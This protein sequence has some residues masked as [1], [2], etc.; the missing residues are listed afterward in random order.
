M[1]PHE[2]FR[3]CQVASY[4]QRVTKYALTLPCRQNRCAGDNC[5]HRLVYSKV[6]G[7]ARKRVAAAL[8]LTIAACS[9][10]YIL[11]SS[12][13]PAGASP[14][15]ALS[16]PDAHTV[17]ILY[18]LDQKQNDQ[19]LISLIDAAKAHVYFAI[20]EF[21]LTD[22]AKALVR[23]KQR[24]VD[25]RGLVDRKESSSSYDAP[26]I[27]LLTDAGI[28]VETQKHASGTGIMHIK[29][30]VTENAYAIGSYNWTRSATTV[31]DE[32]LE[33]GTD[34]DIVQSYATLLERLFTKYEGTSAA[35]A[36]EV[37]SGGTYTTEEAEDHI[38]EY[39][40]V[41]GTLVDA[42][43]SASGTVFLDFCDNYK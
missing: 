17:R 27:S 19:E 41:T 40:S 5:A 21:T 24:G 39:A 30:L 8:V 13:T 6:M 15:S 14:G 2:D 29:A 4:A 42:Y 16:A 23:A 32:V 37:I 12:P 31:N 20:Y 11:G 22:V 35:N 10:G 1:N 26:A 34:P 33:I 3:I 28:P 25:V 18:S 38:G 7:T 43:T 36:A 9:F